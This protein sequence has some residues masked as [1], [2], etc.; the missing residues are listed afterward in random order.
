M[1]TGFGLPDG[2]MKIGLSGLVTGLSVIGLSVIG[3][4]Y[5]LSVIGL[6]YGLSV[7][8]LSVYGLSVSGLSVYGL[9][10]GLVGR[11]VGLGS[12][13]PIA[14][15]GLS[16]LQI[17]LPFN[18]MVLSLGVGG[19]NVLYWTKNLTATAGPGWIFMLVFSILKSLLSEVVTSPIQF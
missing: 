19:F 10:V 9:S 2:C 13:V 7:C 16:A 15:S 17:S 4:S 3:L 12:S 5:G 8:G 14:G 18:L 6:S 11:F 1:S